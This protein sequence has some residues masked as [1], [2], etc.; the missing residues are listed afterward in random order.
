M[1]KKNKELRVGMFVIVAIVLV[2]MVVFSIGDIN[3]FLEKGYHLKV[4]FGFIGGLEVGAPV[5]LAGIITG[6]VQGVKIFYDSALDKIQVEVSIWLKRD[7]KL[8]QDAEIYIN[9]LG[10]LGEKYIEIFSAGTKQAR[11]LKD[12]DKIIGYDPI[13]I[14]RI[15]RISQENLIALSEIL[16]SSETKTSVKDILSNVRDITQDLKEIIA[17]IKAGKGTIG[18]LVVDDEL[19]QNLE[20]FSAD[21]K[22]HPWRLLR[23]EK[24]KTKDKASGSQTPRR[25][26]TTGSY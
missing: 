23:K 10:M 3:L 6:E 24:T 12:G 2:T 25:R 5:R 11:L 14:E 8:R 4:I 26:S 19:Y 15:T 17:G 21:I 1:D 13:P 7:A 20:D 22:A 18:K 9:M 16:G